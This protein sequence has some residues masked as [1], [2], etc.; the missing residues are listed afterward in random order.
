M[1]LEPLPTDKNTTKVQ[2]AFVQQDLLVVVAAAA[3]YSSPYLESLIEV[4]LQNCHFLLVLVHS[5]LKICCWK[6][7]I[8]A[9]VCEEFPKF[10]PKFPKLPKL[11]KALSCAAKVMLPMGSA[12]AAA[13]A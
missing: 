3:D 11:A 5:P 1:Q 6:A 7:C 2:T 13:A 9:A 4:Y 12:A 8:A 10:P